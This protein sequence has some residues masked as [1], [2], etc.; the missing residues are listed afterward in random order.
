[1]DVSFDKVA[2]F[3]RDE[4][5][6]TPIVIV[7]PK[8]IRLPQPGERQKRKRIK[9]HAGRTDLHLVCQFRAMQAKA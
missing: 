5:V 4:E 7:Q 3:E 9:I 8:T 1:M 2:D 6:D